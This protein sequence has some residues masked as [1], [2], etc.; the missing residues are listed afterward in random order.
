MAWIRAVR[1]AEARGRLAE[2]YRACLEREGRVA[3]LLRAQSQ[4]PGC[5]E[6]FAALSRACLFG[7]GTLPVLER[8][9]VALIV[10]RLNGCHYSL[11]L[12]AREVLRL[13]RDEA[14]VRDLREGSRDRLGARTRAVLAYAEK[15][16]RSP[17]EM[18]A[19]DVVTL[20]AHGLDEGQILEVVEITS[21]VNFENRLAQALHVDVEEGM[22]PYPT[23]TAPGPR[24]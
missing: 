19:A 4:R 13:S 1:E 18:S 8:E 11:E 3:E 10:S 23:P 2:A 6:A 7:E 21:F 15:L 9:A 16:T 22:A 20:R 14:L 24:G 17:A 5:L 12:H